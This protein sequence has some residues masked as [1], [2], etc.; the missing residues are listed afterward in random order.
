MLQPTWNCLIN[1]ELRLMHGKRRCF[2]FQAPISFQNIFFIFFWRFWS[3]IISL[4]IRRMGKKPMGIFIYLLQKALKTWFQSWFLNFCT[5]FMHLG[6]MVWPPGGE[7]NEGQNMCLTDSWNLRHSDPDLCLHA[8][9]SSISVMEGAAGNVFQPP[10]S[11][12]WP[13]T[14]TPFS[15]MK[16]ESMPLF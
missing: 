3:H 15:T 6:K 5:H 10:D 4:L 8:G 13:L 14:S 1:W 11:L 2:L 12:V 7:L 16:E 9:A